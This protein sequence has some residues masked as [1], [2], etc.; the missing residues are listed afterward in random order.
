M[1]VTMEP[2][3]T[4]PSD[5]GAAEAP[6]IVVQDLV[7]YYPIFGGLLRRKLGDV[8]AVDG[9]TFEIPKGEVFGLVGESGCGK[10]TLGKTL[11]RLQDP[12]S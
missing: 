3:G 7:K 12:T 11:V 5:G 4:A 9:V 2:S 1:T 8:K 6:L 10:S